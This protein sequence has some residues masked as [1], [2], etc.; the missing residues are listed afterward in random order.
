MNNFIVPPIGIK[1]VFEFNS[2][3]DQPDIDKKE[4]E[5][6]E[7][8]KIKTIYDNGE[9][10]LE[11]IYLAN[12]LTAEDFQNDLE[13]EVPIVTLSLNDV[14]FLY[15]P[16]NRIKKLPNIVGRTA[17]ERL[18][19]ISLGLIPDDINLLT[20][21]KNIEE[22]VKDTL[23]IETNV[24]ETPGGPTVLID[25]TDYNNYI[26]MMKNQ[27][28]SYN[29]SYRV[30]YEEE[31]VRSRVQKELIDKINKIMPELLANKI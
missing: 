29:K 9:E 17:T 23:S 13:H 1:G 3:F 20:L 24:I 15:I 19:T 31:L 4:Y 14:K 27:E 12:N 2:P 28:R 5:V 26:K 8:R 18:I 25:E 11:N 7:I 16:A 10:P 22:M 30:L 6:V 21:Y